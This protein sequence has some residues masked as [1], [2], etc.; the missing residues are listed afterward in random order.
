MWIYDFF[1][2]TFRDLIGTS[3]TLIR[4]SY[5][6]DNIKN[7]A[8]CYTINVDTKAYTTTNNNNKVS[9]LLCQSKREESL[10]ESFFFSSS[11]MIILLYILSGGPVCQW[12]LCI[13]SE[14]KKNHISI[15]V[16]ACEKEVGRD[17]NTKKKGLQTHW[18]TYT[19]KEEIIL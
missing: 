4:S 13:L 12:C 6:R 5:N 15:Y 8:H 18:S 2:H 7:N 10:Y 11:C 16:H 19:E 14:K 3:P 1:P 9:C 17:N